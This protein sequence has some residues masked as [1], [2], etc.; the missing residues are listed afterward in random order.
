MTEGSV[1]YTIYENPYALPVAYYVQSSIENWGYTQY[2]PI[3]SLNDLFT[4][5]TGNGENMYTTLPISVEG[6]SSST[7]KATSGST[8]VTVTPSSSNKTG[9]FVADIAEEGQ[10]YV[11]VDCGAAERITVSG[12]QNKTWS[13]SKSEPYLIDAG[14]LSS[15]TQITVAIT[16]NSTVSG[17]IYV[18]KLNDTVFEQNMA[19][20]AANGMEV[21][22]V[23]ESRISG[24]VTAP[25]DG[26]IYTS[27]PYDKGWSVEV[28][29]QKVET[30]LTGCN[31]MLAFRVGRDPIRSSSASS[32][33]D[34][35]RASS[36]V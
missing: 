18:A 33:A 5:L 10:Y 24:Q 4:D 3:T 17:N 7:A 32:P 25:S 27:I 31:A 26:V 30:L 20:L 34:W 12:A 9:K 6:G 14:V 13:V 2:D 19:T 28:D 29:G 23:S 11:Y 35:C 16:A 15:G 8:A 22:G 21:T 1:T 36:S